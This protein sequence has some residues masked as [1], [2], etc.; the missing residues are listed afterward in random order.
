MDFA[1][2]NLLLYCPMAFERPEDNWLLDV[3]LYSEEFRAD[4]WS[5]LFAE[6]NIE[7]TRPVREYAKTVSAFFASK[8][9]RAKLRGLREKYANERELK[10]G[11]FGVLCGAKTYG[12]AEVVKQVLSCSPEDEPTALNAMAKFCGENAFWNACEEVYGYAGAPEELRLAAYLLATAALNVSGA[13]APTGP[14]RSKPTASL[15]AGSMRIGRPS[16]RCASVW[17]TRSTWPPC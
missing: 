8:E 3:F 11:I 16:W 1:D 14:M 5:L 7:N 10:T 2:E 12:F 13:S 4:Y 9:R 6:L 17:K 15:P